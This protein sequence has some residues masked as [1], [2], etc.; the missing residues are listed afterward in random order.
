MIGHVPEAGTLGHNNGWHFPIMFQTDTI[1]N[2]AEK[3]T[4]NW[5]S[6]NQ[7]T[8][9]SI[10]RSL[11]QTAASTHSPDIQQELANMGM[12]VCMIWRDVMMQCNLA[13][14]AYHSSEPRCLSSLVRCIST[15]QS[16]FKSQRPM[17]GHA[18]EAG[19]LGHNNGWHLPII[20]QT[21]SA[22]KP[23]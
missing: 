12:L 21:S 18:T 2:K 3:L 13:I 15:G 1:S 20:K 16:R 17:I 11:N 14:E 22:T 4:M 10:N 19:T 7:A 6:S 8:N 9:Q 23:E 5:K